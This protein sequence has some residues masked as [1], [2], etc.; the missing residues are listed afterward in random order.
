MVNAMPKKAKISA[1]LPSVV[2][3]NI[4]AR[5]A[6]LGLTQNELALALGVEVETI[7]R[8]ERGTVAP[9]FPQLEKL[10][11]ALQ[12]QA[13]QLFSDGSVVPDAK[14][15]TLDDLLARLSDRD[16]EF[17]LSFVRDY[18]AHHGKSR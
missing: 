17:V 18:V 2:G 6:E 16:R 1:P 15:H 5:R 4:K 8:Y 13:W 3:S 12:V 9:S 10:C 14:G 11:A 7:S